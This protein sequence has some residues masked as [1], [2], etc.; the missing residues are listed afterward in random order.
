VFTAQG[1]VAASKQR[2]MATLKEN[3]QSSPSAASF[4][5]TS[6]SAGLNKLNRSLN[7]TS[8]TA[9][10]GEMLRGVR[11]NRRFQLQMQH[12]NLNN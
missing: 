12:R 7:Q 9:S 3:H 4:K 6:I 8:S 1:L 2:V 5:K 11:V 10:K